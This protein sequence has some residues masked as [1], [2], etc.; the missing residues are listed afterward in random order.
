MRMST[1]MQMMLCFNPIQINRINVY[2][3]VCKLYKEILCNKTI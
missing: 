3:C 1:G 2:K